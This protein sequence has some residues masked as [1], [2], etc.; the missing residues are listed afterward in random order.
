ME[1]ILLD[2]N[3]LELTGDME[4]L[5]Q[6]LDQ[7]KAHIPDGRIISHLFLDEREVFEQSNEQLR[8]W[9]LAPIHVVRI[10]T[11]TVNA[12]VLTSLADLQTF[13][14]EV[15]PVL[16]QSSRELRFGAVP[17]AAG[18]L[19][20]C[21]E[22]LDMAVRSIE[23][24]VMVLPRLN[25]GLSDQELACFSKSEVDL[26]GE[27]VSDFTK[28]DWLSVADRIEFQL[29]PLMGRWQ[30]VIN[31]VSATLKTTPAPAQGS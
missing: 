14:K 9:S 19:A 25:A 30:T 11:T 26:L 1:Q 24:I 18:R 12:Q 29:D 27:L 4:H 22:G 17:G 10:N 28:K 16:R 6:L 3:R 31:R 15:R 5:G 20:D 21:F 13:L 8:S 7:I 2:G 23:Q